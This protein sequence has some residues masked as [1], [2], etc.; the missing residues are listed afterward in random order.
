MDVTDRTAATDPGAD[1]ITIR[2]EVEM[3][4]LP[5]VSQIRV[6]Q[7]NLAQPVLTEESPSTHIAVARAE[8]I[9]SG[10]QGITCRHVRAIFQI[11]NSG[12]DTLSAVVYENRGCACDHIQRL[13]CQV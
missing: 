8:E 9:N 2:L 7:A 3:R 4:V 1:W 6:R 13:N 5:G 10:I 12:R 11:C